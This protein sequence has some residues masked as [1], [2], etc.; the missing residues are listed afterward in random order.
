MY[1]IGVMLRDKYNDFLDENY[2]A[3]DVYAYS[4]F[5]YRTRM[6]VQLALAGLYPPTKE[7]LWNPNIKWQPLPSAFVPYEQDVILSSYLSKK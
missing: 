7:F 4:T 5:A 3:Q 2:K 6:S 1:N